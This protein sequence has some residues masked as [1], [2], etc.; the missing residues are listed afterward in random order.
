M[1]LY[2]DMYVHTLYQWWITRF[3]ADHFAVGY[4]TS[5]I[6]FCGSEKSTVS[7]AKV[8]E[9][10]DLLSK[11]FLFATSTL[12]FCYFILPFSLFRSYYFL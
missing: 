7:H 10:I 3:E 2:L 6:V 12:S 4:W 1:H 8:I 11:T 5:F 9:G